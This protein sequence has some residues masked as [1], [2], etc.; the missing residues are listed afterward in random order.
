MKLELKHLAPYL[1]YKLKIQNSKGFSVRVM[2][3]MVNDNKEVCIDA[4][5][6]MQYKPILRPLSDLTKEIEI[7]G[8]KFTPNLNPM[9]KIFIQWEL[10]QFQAEPRNNCTLSQYEKLLE[11]H[12]DV[13]G[14]LPKN[15]A[16][17]INT[18][19]Q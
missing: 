5:F 17:D 15:L 4:V 11:W 7:N 9:F 10:D 18:I 6:R 16:V 14:L 8:R 12:F 19:K 13:F 2:G 1:P 3:G